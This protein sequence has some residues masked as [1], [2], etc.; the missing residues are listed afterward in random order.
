MVLMRLKLGLVLEDHSFRFCISTATCSK[1]TSKWIEHLYVHL[2]FLTYWPTREQIDNN[3]PQ[4]FWEMFPRT[5]VTIDCT[6]L[7]TDTPSSLV[8]QSL[9]FSH[10]KTHMTWKAL[11]GVTPN[12]VVSFV[13][14]LWGGSIS[15]KQ[16]VQRSGLLELCQEGDAVMGD[17]GFL[18][19]DLTTPRGIE[20]IV[21]PKKQG[22]KQMSRRD[23]TLTRRVA[24]VR[25]HVERHM[26]RVKNFRILPNLTGTMKAS[27]SKIWKICNH[28]TALQPPT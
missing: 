8:E 20:L 24:N 5:R 19:A 16:I 28:L 13:S 6:E 1:I 22:A 25:I 23:V 11:I 10:Y 14:D 17:K 4:D 2:S 9:M 3:M 27:V 18:I 7:L 15:D 12:G 26:E 21:P